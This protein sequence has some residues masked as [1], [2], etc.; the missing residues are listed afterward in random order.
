LYPL[1]VLEF[2]LFMRISHTN[3]NRKSMRLHNRKALLFLVKNRCVQSW[4]EG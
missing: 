2:R 1:L 4:F 3:T